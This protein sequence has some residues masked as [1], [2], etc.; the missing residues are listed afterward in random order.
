MTDA[1][2]IVAG[3]GLT[4]AVLGGYAAWVVTRRR[5]LARSLKIDHGSK[6]PE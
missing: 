1:A 2:Y 5:S 4:T 3:Y 6:P